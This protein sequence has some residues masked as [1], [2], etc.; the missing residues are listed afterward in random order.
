MEETGVDLLGMT[1]FV[2]SFVESH[3]GTRRNTEVSNSEE[4]VSTDQPS[5]ANLGAN[6]GDDTPVLAASDQ[7]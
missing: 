6:P 1:N 5:V 4:Q 2:D 3:A 7:A